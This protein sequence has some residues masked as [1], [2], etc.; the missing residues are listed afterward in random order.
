MKKSVIFL[1][2][3]ALCLAAGCMM[4]P[5]AQ[6]PTAEPTAKPTVAP[7]ME[8]TVAPTIEPTIEPTAEPTDAPVVVFPLPVTADLA[9]LTDCTLAVAFDKS[10]VTAD[11]S[12]A[13][14]LTATV[15]VYDLYDMV[16]ISLLQE[17]DTLLMNG[18][19]L[20]IES[21]ERTQSGA[22][23]LNGGLDNG[24]HDLFTNENGV[25][26]ETGYSDVKSYYELGEVTL[27]FA[28]DAVFT[29]GMDLDAGEVTYAPA[30]LL[31]EESGIYDSFTPHNT[32]IVVQDG[33]IVA[34]A[35][36]YTP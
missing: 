8:P 16:D 3:A 24:G 12:G 29:D 2:I 11:E 36:I 7:T 28:P 19:P 15:Y 20:V 27:P 35:R 13:L 5:A 22:V 23:L 10:C 30:D 25:Y 31:D 1:L 6:T 17:G 26:F 9:N 21:I 4:Q 14:Q 32:S 18:Q 34:M 33:Q